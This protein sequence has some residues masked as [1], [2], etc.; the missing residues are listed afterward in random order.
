MHGEFDISAALSEV[1][2]QVQFHCSHNHAKTFWSRAETL[3]ALSMLN[4][5]RIRNRGKDHMLLLRKAVP[6]F[7][8]RVSFFYMLCHSLFPPQEI[9]FYFFPS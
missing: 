2:F 9:R 5:S 8:H 6:S 1:H 3:S 4:I 7:L